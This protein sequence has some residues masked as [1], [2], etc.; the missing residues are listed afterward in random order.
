MRESTLPKTLVMT[1][2]HSF[3]A[4]GDGRARGFRAVPCRAFL[5]L[6]RTIKK[7]D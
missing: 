4:H 3:W 1:Q 5:I 2:Q 7:G 6:P